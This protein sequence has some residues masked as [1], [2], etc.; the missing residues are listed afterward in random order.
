MSKKLIALGLIAAGAALYLKSRP[1]APVQGFGD[2]GR[3]KPKFKNVAKTVLTSAIPIVGP[4]MAMRQA[5]KQATFL[6]SKVQKALVAGTTMAIPIVGSAMLT[7][8]AVKGTLK[9]FRGGK[10]QTEGSPASDQAPVYQDAKGNT[11][12]EAQ[13]NMIMQVVG[14]LVPPVKTGPGALYTDSAGQQFTADEYAAWLQAGGAPADGAYGGQVVTDPNAG[15][16]LYYGSG[17]SSSGGGQSS[18]GGGGGGGGGGT[19]YTDAASA[20]DSPATSPGPA[21][22]QQMLAPTAAETVA[23]EQAPKKIS[24]LV[25]FGTLLAVPIFM[26]MTGGK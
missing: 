5:A 21:P 16:Q 7:H 13:Y 11:I 1:A 15:Q 24:P 14:R 18:G 23:E 19:S 22:A 6:P 20:F 4:S 25:V 3:W 26:G 10:A 9:K 8:Q 17:S 12:T 2:L